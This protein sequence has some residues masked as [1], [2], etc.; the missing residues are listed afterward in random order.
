MNVLHTA[1]F[2]FVSIELFWLNVYARNWSFKYRREKKRTLAIEE[3]ITIILKK[4]WTKQKK[5]IG[6]TEHTATNQQTKES[7]EEVEG[8]K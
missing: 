4:E 6:Y 5:N 2:L 3:S 1:W 8:K 7:N